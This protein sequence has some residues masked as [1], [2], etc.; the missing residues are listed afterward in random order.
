M[1][2]MRGFYLNNPSIHSTK[3]TTPNG[4]VEKMLFVT[5]GYQS[6]DFWVSIDFFCQ[7]SPLRFVGMRFYRK[8]KTEK[9]SSC[10]IKIGQVKASKKIACSSLKEMAQF[11]LIGQCNISFFR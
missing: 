5:C 6:R 9:N 8:V 3:F 1:K 2:R 7:T 11:T 4:P 10:T